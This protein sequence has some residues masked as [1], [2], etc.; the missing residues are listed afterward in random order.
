MVKSYFESEG[1]QEMKKESVPF[2]Q[3]YCP[4][5]KE[6][7]RPGEWTMC[8]YFDGKKLDFSNVEESIKQIFRCHVQCGC[9]IQYQYF[10]GDKLVTKTE[11]IIK[12]QESLRKIL[13]LVSRSKAKSEQKKPVKV[14]IADDDADFLEMH[15]AVLKN[16]GYTVFTAE[17]S[18]ECLKKFE[19]VQPDIIVLDVMMEQFDTGFE[20]CK[21]IKSKNQNVPVILLTAIGAQTGLEFSSSEEVLKFTKADILLDKPVSP[22]VFIDAIEK[23][24]TKNKS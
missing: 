8:P 3:V 6:M 19:E 22:K 2:V 13:L 1:E 11:N 24:T 10:S 17:N 15:S 5:C 16:R 12:D 18:Q 9:E 7:I 20:V 23:L 14:L 21:T 4:E